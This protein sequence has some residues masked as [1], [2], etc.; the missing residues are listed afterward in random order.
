MITLINIIQIMLIFNVIQMLINIPSD[1]NVCSLQMLIDIPR[2]ISW[3]L[4]WYAS[5][6][7][8][9][10]WWYVNLHLLEGLVGFKGILWFN[11]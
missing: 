5:S 7:Q 1:Y 11:K 10:E 6:D 4:W 8:V 9:C 2:L 3:M